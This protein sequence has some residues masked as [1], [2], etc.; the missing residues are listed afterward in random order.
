MV[1]ISKRTDKD[2][3]FEIKKTANLKSTVKLDLNCKVK[4]EKSEVQKIVGSLT[5]ETAEPTEQ[6]QRFRNRTF[7]VRL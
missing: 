3:K 1:K 4:N 6:V 2:L 7:V 5:L